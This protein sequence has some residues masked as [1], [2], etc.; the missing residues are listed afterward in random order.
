MTRTAHLLDKHGLENCTFLMKE[1][2]FSRSFIQFTM[3]L[4]GGSLLYYE[5]SGLDPA[6]VL[7]LVIMKEKNSERTQKQTEPSI[8]SMTKK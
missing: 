1:L 3:G 2:K 7:I 6:G 8:T 5:E 4:L